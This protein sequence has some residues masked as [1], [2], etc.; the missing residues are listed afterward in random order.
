V[1]Q[2]SPAQPSALETNPLG[3]QLHAAGLPVQQIRPGAFKLNLHGEVQFP[4]GSATLPEAAHGPLDQ[5]A[6]ILIQFPDARVRIIGRADHRGSIEYNKRLSLLRA[7]AVAE[8]L[9]RRGVAM[10]RI[11]FEGRGEDQGV[12]ATSE[13]GRKLLA[14][15]RRVD[16]II[17]ERQSLRRQPAPLQPAAARRSNAM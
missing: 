16:L 1:S 8:Y 10:A 17:E 5:V 13:T 2:D 14:F 6:A 12:K 4:L 9:R 15:E 11:S 7:K 3:A